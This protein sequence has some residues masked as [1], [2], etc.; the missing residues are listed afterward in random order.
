MVP[1][2]SAFRPSTP[3]PA[4]PARRVRH[5]VG[6]D[7]ICQPDPSPG[8]K[9]HPPPAAFSNNSPSPSLTFLHRPFVP[10]AAPSSNYSLPG[11]PGPHRTDTTQ[12]VGK[13]VAV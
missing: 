7:L 2:N 13:N 1:V 10:Q 9:T 8:I 3:V 12:P 11:P 6:A 5:G 4:L